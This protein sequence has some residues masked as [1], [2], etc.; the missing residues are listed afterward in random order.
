M[1]PAEDHAG[2]LPE[3][4]NLSVDFGSGLGN[5]RQLEHVQSLKASSRIK[6]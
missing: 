5:S 6:R 3:Y 4:S 2:S 1:P